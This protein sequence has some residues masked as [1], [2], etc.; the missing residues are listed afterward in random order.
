MKQNNTP[1]RRQSWREIADNSLYSFRYVLKNSKAFL[2]VSLLDVLT[3]FISPLLLAL[4][5]RAYNLLEPGGSFPPVAALLI[6]LTASQALSFLWSRIYGQYILPKYSHR[7]HRRTRE[8][9]FRQAARLDLAMYDDPEFYNDLLLA[10]QYSGSCAAG[11]VSTVTSLLRCIVDISATLALLV[12]IDMLSMAVLCLSTALSLLITAVSNR[13]N[14]AMQRELTPI[15]RREGY[16]ERLY[17]SPEHAKELRMTRLHECAERDFEL[18]ALE[19]ERA[20]KRLGLRHALIGVAEC[21]NNSL[22]YI[23]VIALTVYRYAVSGTVTIGDFSVFATANMSFREKLRALGAVWIELPQKSREISLVRRFID[24]A[25]E[26]TGSPRTTHPE[27]EVQIAEVQEPFGQ[28]SNGQETD[29]TEADISKAPET[30]CAVRDVA[31]PCCAAEE[32]PPFESLELRDVHFAYTQGGEVLR[33]VSMK[34]GRGEKIALVGC[35]GA[36]KSTLINLIMRLY[37]PDSGSILYNGRPAQ[38]LEICSY[39]QRISTVFQSY[40]LFA[41]TLA[42]NVLADTYTDS[43][44]KRVLDA[45]HR[46][47]FD[48]RLAAMKE[49]IHT[50]LTREF[51]EGGTCLSGGEAQKVAVAR[52][53]AADRDIIIMDE[54]SASLD[55]TAE[56]ELN[57]QIADL[58]RDKTVIFISHRLSSTRHADRIYLLD[59]GMIAECGT[60]DELMASGGKYAEMFRAQAEKYLLGEAKIVRIEKAKTS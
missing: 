11:A 54:P 50:P 48:G 35:N 26:K 7:L 46:A 3:G 31:E 36:G 4:S 39:R 30:G 34:L 43:E 49:G 17:S 14:F 13:H 28:K 45:L 25:P 15:S 12:Y 40:R 1:A 16:I 55:P 18:T 27:S 59:G 6:L 58:A 57:R 52:A 38:E 24:D 8:Q 5:R 9:L 10:M 20:L 22:G 56:Y 2:F 60:H 51:D 32:A 33:G 29:S 37:S 53:I 21:L 41:A 19:H 47:G 42:E 23:A 44:R